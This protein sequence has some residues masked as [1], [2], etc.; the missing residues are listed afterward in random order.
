MAAKVASL[1]E[2]FGVGEADLRAAIS[3]MNEEMGIVGE[4]PLPV[5]VDKLVA[6][7][8]VATAPAVAASAALAAASAASKSSLSTARSEGSPAASSSLPAPV[9]ACSAKQPQPA[10]RGTATLTIQA[11][12]LAVVAQAYHRSNEGS[13]NQKYFEQCAQMP[14]TRVS[15]FFRELTSRVS[16]HT[17][18]ARVGC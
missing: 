5:Q 8:G 9:P 1:R 4:G 13:A 15:E 14:R 10:K 12:R 6:E 2:F 7:T 18:A 3:K 11:D 16:C 17:L